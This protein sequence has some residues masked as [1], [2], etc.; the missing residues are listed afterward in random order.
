VYAP[1]VSRAIRSFRYARL[2]VVVL[3]EHLLFL[4]KYGIP[5]NPQDSCG[6]DTQPYK[7]R[8]PTREL[9]EYSVLTE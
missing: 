9:D 5:L 8:S 7:A 2:W 4:I 6:S 1:L 3:A